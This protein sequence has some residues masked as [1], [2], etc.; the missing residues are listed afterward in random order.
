[1]VGYQPKPPRKQKLVPQ[2]RTLDHSANDSVPWE[3][4]ASKILTGT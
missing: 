4:H 1:M 3:I 2:C